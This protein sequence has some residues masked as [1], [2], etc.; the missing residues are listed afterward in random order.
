MWPC[1]YGKLKGQSPSPD[2]GERVCGGRTK[3]KPSSLR[4][5]KRGLQGRSRP[6]KIKYL[7]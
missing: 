5:C 3:P 2:P 6:S 7:M 4:K 1:Q